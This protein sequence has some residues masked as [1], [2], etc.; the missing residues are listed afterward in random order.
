MSAPVAMGVPVSAAEKFSLTR[1]VNALTPERIAQQHALMAAYDEACNALIGPN[2][3]QQDKGRTF[4]KKS[5]WRKL[6]RHFG[7]SVHCDLNSVRIER[8]DGGF[9]AFAVAEATAPWRQSW[10]DVGACASDEETGRRVIT[11]ADAVGTAMTR[12]SNRAISNLIAMGE[13]SAE[14]IGRHKSRVDN[15]TGPDHSPASTRSSDASS[16]GGP[17]GVQNGPAGTAS[18]QARDTTSAIREQGGASRSPAGPLAAYDFVCPKCGGTDHWDNREN[19]KNPRGPDFKCKN[20]NC[21]EGVWLDS[22]PQPTQSARS[23][24]PANFE[25]FP[26][27]LQDEEDFLP[28]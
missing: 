17:T 22:Q 3:V 27:A 26:A 8:H 19:K 13:V 18:Y 16:G 25:E 11:E 12:A 2:D 23:S 9:V 4:K 24:A 15:R 6:A 10:T 14:E 21:G 28:F 7:I 1:Y 20:R 5:A